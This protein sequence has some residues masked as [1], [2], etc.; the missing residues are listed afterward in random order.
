MYDAPW[1]GSEVLWTHTAA[2]ALAQGH[3]VLVSF[4]AWPETA[5]PLQA[6]EAKGAQVLR[7]TRYEPDLRRRAVK[8]LARAPWGGQLPEVRALAQFKPDIV[9]INQ[10]GW[11]DLFFHKQ[12]ADWLRHVPF[13]LACHNYQD[14]VRQR[15]FSRAQIGHMYSQAKEVLMISENQLCTLQRQL[16]DPIA[17]ARV[18][19]N[20]L[21]LPATYPVPRSS[22]TNNAV[23]LAVVASFDVDRKGQDVLLQALTASEWAERNVCLNFYGKGPDQV[24]LEQ[25]I[26]FYGLAGRVRLCGH[27]DDAAAIWRENDLLVIPSRIESGP[28]VLQEAMLCGR[29]VVAT[30]VGMVREWL[31]DD[32]TG[33]I[34]DASSATSLNKALS[35][36]WARRAD[37]PTMGAQAA[38]RTHTRLEND[39]VGDL[40]QR[41][42]SYAVNSCL[43]I[44]SGK[45][46]TDRR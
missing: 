23:Q 37:W 17:N 39:S 30:D 22:T 34:A 16:V 7:R 33:F 11:M 46:L 15:D 9:L 3:E 24:Y 40:L 38:A 27:V 6:L 29:P 25:L 28:M 10:A 2:R 14:P 36:A 12:L 45:P 21:N 18:V 31:D 41:L 44:Q 35:R 26:H 20:P 32:E 42:V 5:A 4:Y 1:G 13:V 19:Q 8:W 43:P